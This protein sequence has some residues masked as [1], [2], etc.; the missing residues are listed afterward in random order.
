M[1]F[2][3]LIDSYRAQF[4]QQNRLIQLKIDRKNWDEQLLALA[5]EGSETLSDSGNRYQVQA[6]ALDNQLD[7]TTLIGLSACLSVRNAE[8]EEIN[9]AGLVHSV[10]SLG[11]DGGFS[12]YSIDIVPPVQLLAQRV[13]SR[14]FQNM[15]VAA[16]IEQILQEHRAA[17]PV[18]A[19]AQTWRFDLKSPESQLPRSFCAQ[20]RQSDFDFMRRLMAEEGFSWYCRAD[21]NNPMVSELHIVQH[22]YSLA[23]A[24]QGEIQF[25][26]N[27]S[28]ELQDGFQHWQVGR[29]LTAGQHELVSYDYKMA[30]P[31]LSGDRSRLQLGATAQKLQSSLNV[32]D[33][34]GQY[35]AANSNG[36]SHYAS[37]RQ[38]AEDAKSTLISARGAARSLA[39]GQWF[40][41]A[42]HPSMVLASPGQREFVVTQMDFT[43][44]SNLPGELMQALQQRAPRLM[45]HLSAQ[46]D[47]PPY[48]CQIQAQARSA[49]L[50]P[51]Y[52]GTEL[53][54]PTAC[55]MQTAT[56]VGPANEEVYTDEQGRVR[57]QFHW[58]RTE[59]HPNYGA[60][61]NENSSCWIRVAYPIAGSG[62]GTQFIPRIGQEVLVDFIEGDADR[63]VI[64]GVLFNGTHSPVKFSKQVGLPGNKTLSGFKSSEH[65]G[66]GY[67]QMLF[68]DTNKKIR[69]QIVSSHG[70][71]A[72]NLGWLGSARNEGK[73]SARGEGFELR[74]ELQGSIRAA[75]GL[76]LSTEAQSGEGQQLD[77][78]Q[79]LQQLQS[80]V[81]LCQQLAS[82][83]QQQL[84][85]LQETGPALIDSDNS[86][87][88][89][90]AHGHQQHLLDAAK[91]WAHGSN[92]APD[93]QA[94]EQAGQ[95]PIML[96][97]SASGIASVSA[98]STT[99][100]AGSNLDLVAQRDSNQTSGRRWI[101]N[102]GQHISLFVRG[103]KDK[104]SCKLIAAQG[105]MQLQ[106][107]AGKLELSADQL[108]KIIS[109]KDSVEIY[110]PKQIL[111]NVAGGSYI[112]MNSAGIQV[113]CPQQLSLKGDTH[114]FNGP[115]Q[116]T[117]EL[118]QFPG[119][120]CKACLARA[121]AE[122]NPLVKAN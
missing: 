18:F 88:G 33:A 51:R 43:A 72:L 89:H 67:N 75:K 114:D 92:T 23:Q 69:A 3:S 12:F 71:S 36:L 82:S 79:A 56:V 57:V 104:V 60:D 93:A 61:Y 117:P 20:Y 21:E 53:A 94:G 46:Q 4:T 50:V 122:A 83:A 87:Q 52:F 11:S 47:Q 121:S 5:V 30:R 64:I 2:Y 7:L 28:A 19:R 35:Y 84:A 115:A 68:D 31:T 100:G 77:R 32:Y 103:V 112:R 58:Q 113:H 62:W 98:H 96:L 110:A 116:L 39:C 80:I 49:P 119:S 34:P 101:H 70:Y 105:H 16:I 76:L 55:G 118:P 74:S 65:F 10:T 90:S 44:R 38:Q 111:L 106:A 109:A 25:H 97:S 29:Q 54:K 102:V 26:R 41:L 13:T 37:L 17:N 78:S 15:T 91:A 120:V 45:P 14:V 81:E 66:Y 1:D 85:D 48:Q 99:I 40:R 86:Q 24:P 6:L 95:Q 108:L 9:R 42:N 22:V 8:G 107:Q 63:P 27:S 73:T 59:E